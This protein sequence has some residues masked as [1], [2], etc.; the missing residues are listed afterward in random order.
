MER[1]NKPDTGKEEDSP[2]NGELRRLAKPPFHTSTAPETGSKLDSAG[3]E[4]AD[5]APVKSAAATGVVSGLQV[6]VCTGQKRPPD[7]QGGGGSSK[8]QKRSH[9]TAANQKSKSTT[10]SDSDELS[11]GESVSKSQS[12][13]P[14]SAGV[15]SHQTKSPAGTQSPGKRGENGEKASDLKDQNNP[16]PGVYQWSFQMSELENLS[17]AERI[18]VLQEKL[19]EV[20]K[21]YLC[22]KSEVASIDRRRKLLKRKERET[23]RGPKIIN[24]EKPFLPVARYFTPALLVCVVNALPL[25]CCRCIIFLL[26]TFLQFQYGCGYVNFSRT[27]Y[28]KFLPEWNVS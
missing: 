23:N 26:L 25:A 10:S 9:K 6:V 18:T 16:L 4:T 11:A 22:L 2:Q 21:R 20:R 15:K 7:G 24:Q 1:E 5:R 14:V 17:S 13:K 28:V 12:A 8:K 3:A 27:V 19:Q